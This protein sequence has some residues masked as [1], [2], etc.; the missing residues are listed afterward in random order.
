MLPDCTYVILDLP[1]ALLCSSHWLNRVLPDDCAPY[2]E[3][4]ELTSLS[5][6]TLLSRKVWTLAAHQIEAIT[7]RSVDAFV[8]IYSF[9]EMP[10]SAID[11]YF[12]Q[13]SR[14]TDGVLYSKQRKVEKNRMDGIEV[15][16]AT[17]PVQS[18]WELLFER[19]TILYEA[20]FEAAYAVGRPWP[21]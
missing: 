7:D 8:S 21:S 9:A 5:R 12:S 18:F 1:E 19:T 13:L 2:E 4:R 20:F 14:V 17:Y 15:T 6:E 10:R 16:A 3:S 11:N